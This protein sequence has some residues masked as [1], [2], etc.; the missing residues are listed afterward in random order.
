MQ[1]IQQ[2]NWGFKPTN[3]KKIILINIPF[4]NKSEIYR[5]IYYNFFFL[6]K[7]CVFFFCEEMQR[8]NNN[9]NVIF[10][11]C[12]FLFLR[13]MKSLEWINSTFFCFIKDDTED[14]KHKFQMRNVR[15]KF[16]LEDHI[17]I[18]TCNW[19]CTIFFFRSFWDQTLIGNI[20]KGHVRCFQW[21]ISI[22]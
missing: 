20:L 5:D 19:S 15:Y 6:K 3:R 18:A 16:V 11:H 17:H 22:Q 12:I 7:F 8:K 21:N 1:N 4:S 14:N 2:Y 10:S 9:G 13:K